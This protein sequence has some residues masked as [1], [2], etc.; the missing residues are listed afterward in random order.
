MLWRERDMEESSFWWFRDFDIKSFLLL[1]IFC[2]LSH[3][4]RFNYTHRNRYV[5]YAFNYTLQVALR[6]I[7]FSLKNYKGQANE[8]GAIFINP[9]FKMT[10]I[11]KIRGLL[12]YGN[13]Y[14]VSNYIH[15]ISMS[16]KMSE[17]YHNEYRWLCVEDNMETL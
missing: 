11:C 9:S 12:T 10:S 7:P 6:N 14:N 4:E 3:M 13:T 17:L 8:Y 16:Y 5:W 15:E 1:D 2:M